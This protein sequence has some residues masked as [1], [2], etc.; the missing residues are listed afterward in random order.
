MYLKVGNVILW[1]DYP[2]PRS[3][4]IKAR[5]FIYLGRTSVLTTPVFAYLCTTTTQLQHF[6]PGG[7][8]SNHTCK[9]F[10]VR[11]FPL[12]E[13]NC[14]I[15]FDE[16]LHEIP[17]ATIDKCRAHIEI[18]GQLDENTLR[19]IFKQFSRPGVVSPVILRDIFDSFNRDGI[20]GLKKPK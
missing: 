8:R 15:D 11:Q 4:K 7:S 5:W 6:D 3:G 1:G 2:S 12:F 13:R 18:R 20:T 10:D 9:R 19:N 17:E 16:D 14:V